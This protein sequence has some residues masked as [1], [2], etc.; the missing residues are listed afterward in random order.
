MFS[1]WL[2]VS[3]AIMVNR[4]WPQKPRPGASGKSRTALNAPPRPPH[5]S[6]MNRE[7]RHNP[8]EADR[9][10][11]HRECAQATIQRLRGFRV[12]A[13]SAEA[14]PASSFAIAICGGLRWSASPPMRFGLGPLA[15]SLNALRQRVPPTLSDRRRGF[16]RR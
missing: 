8:H 10:V 13:D 1:M 16:P 9:D 6:G 5:W 2:K 15:A 11:E 14:K 12:D 4:P 3:G 7:T